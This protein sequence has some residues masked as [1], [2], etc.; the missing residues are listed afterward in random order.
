MEF[1]SFPKFLS[2]NLKNSMELVEKIKN[3]KV[4][5]DK[6]LVSF[7]VYSLIQSIPKE[8]LL[9]VLEN[10][11]LIFKTPIG[12]LKLLDLYLHLCLNHHLPI[13][14]NEKSFSLALSFLSKHQ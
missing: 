1:T 3:I 7:D 8:K 11:K 6:C 14:R 2:L 12:R 9:R 5:D 13:V 4:N 10:L